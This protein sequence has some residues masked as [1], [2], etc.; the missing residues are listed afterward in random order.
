[1]LKKKPKVYFADLRHQSGS[2][3]ANPAMPLGISYM[4]AVMDRDLPEV[5]SRI[6]AYPDQLLEVMKS[7]APDVLMLTNYVW[8]E[9]LSL[10][11]T[12]LAKQMRPDTLVVAGGPN[13]PLEVDQAIE[14]FNRWKELDVYALGEGDFLATEIV[15]RFLDANK[16]ISNFTKKGIPSSLYWTE[17]EVVHQPLW[18]KELDLEKIPSPWL[19]GVQDHF[20]DGTLIPL[21]ETNRGCPFKCSF[22]VQG[23]DFYNRMSHFGEDRVKEEL[24]YIAHRIRKVCPGMNALT[25]ADPNFGMY[26]RDVDIA[27]HIGALQNDYNWPSFIDCSTGKNAPELVI[28]AIE[29]TNGALHMLHAVQSMDNEVLKSIKRSNIKLEAYGTVTSHLKEMGIRTFSQ[30]ILGLPS[31]TLQT[32]L[33][34]LRQLLDNG[35][36]SLQNF[37]LMLLK[38]SEMGSQDNRD[39][40]GFKSKFRVSPGCFGTYGDKS[41][42]DVEEVV[43]ATESLSHEDYLYARKYHL[44]YMIYWNQ[45]WFEDLFGFTKN[46]GIKNSICLEAIAEAMNSDCGKMG[47]FMSEFIKET[48]AELFS[49]AEECFQ[50]YSEGNRIDNLVRGEIGDNLLNKYRAIASFVL[51]PQICELA[52]KVFK[53]LIKTHENENLDPEFEF[54]WEDICQY[55]GSKHAFGQ[56]LDE[57][58]SPV[59]C[60]LHYDILRWVGDGSPKNFS[61]YRLEASK[62][63][64]LKLSPKNAKEISDAIGTWSIGLRGLVKVARYLKVTSQVRQLDYA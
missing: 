21:I 12:N 43:V 40:F 29:K 56:S 50:Y 9:Q 51:W 24:S 31:E 7:D 22:C 17:G 15:S 45:D 46:L 18:E 37:Q 3:I 32:H 57:I 26:K 19:S 16:S 63:F 64:E 35:I 42:F 53:E 20:F 33:T 27:T 48:Q 28:K 14:T 39:R 44:V 36:D 1:M 62:A 47:E 61:S 49:S 2:Q 8:N 41:I 23:V 11:F 55:V 34:G 5:E 52:A 10:H 60:Q 13:I 25:I 54:F 59:S 6:F 38:G 4:K 30:T 58:L